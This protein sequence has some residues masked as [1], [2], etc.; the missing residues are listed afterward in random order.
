MTGPHFWRTLQ[1]TLVAIFLLSIATAI[2]PAQAPTDAGGPL[3]NTDITRLLTIGVSERTV[4]AVIQEAK[5]R[6]FDR[7][8]AAISL[9]KAGGVPDAVIAAIQRTAPSAAAESVGIDRLK[10]E[11]VYAAGQALGKAVTGAGATL[12][13]IDRLLQTFNA[14]VAAARERASTP[15]E[16]SLA[17]SYAVARLHF[18]AGLS[19]MNVPQRMEAWTKANEALEQANKIYTAK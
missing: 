2:L 14:E 12:G 9:L 8:A 18:E 6:Q 3:I 13:Q 4:L 7:S 17:T 16:R 19:Q 11:K 5:E 15:A 10:F 1:I